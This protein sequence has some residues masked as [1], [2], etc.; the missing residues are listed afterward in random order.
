MWLLFE[1]G[2]IVVL[3]EWPNPRT[4]LNYWFMLGF[5]LRWSEREVNGHEI[6]MTSIS[7]ILQLIEELPAYL[8]WEH[9]TS[10]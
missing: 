6:N 10:I 3:M 9:N 7:W 4:V 5:G 2:I 8:I 1:C